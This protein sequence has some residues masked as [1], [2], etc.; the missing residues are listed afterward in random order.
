M[1]RLLRNVSTSMMPSLSRNSITSG[2]WN[3][4]PK[5]SGSMM[6]KPSH[7]LSRMSGLRPSHSLNHSSASI[8]LGM[9]KNSQSNTPARNRPR[10]NGR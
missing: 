7:S 8:A 9:T 3:D 1:R 5:T 2:V 6:A 4:T 10:L